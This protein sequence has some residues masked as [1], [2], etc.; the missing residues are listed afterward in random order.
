MFAQGYSWIPS[1]S[2]SGV[3]PNAVLAGQDVDG[4][5]IY[6]GR[7][8]HEGDQVPAKVLPSKNIAYIAFA[9]QE[10]GKQNFDVSSLLLITFTIIQFT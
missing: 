7:A 6:V 1:S 10:I 4:A 5:P 9:G 3:P 8:F 2:Y